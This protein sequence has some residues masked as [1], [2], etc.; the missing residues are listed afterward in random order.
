MKWTKRVLQ[1]GDRRTFKK[2]T[3]LPCKLIPDETLDG[4]VWRTHVW[5][6][7]VEVTQKYMPVRRGPQHRFPAYWATVSVVLTH[8]G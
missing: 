2:F 8:K 5:L 1:V 4:T 7:W 3:L 6:E